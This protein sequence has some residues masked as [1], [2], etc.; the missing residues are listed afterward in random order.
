MGFRKLLWAPLFWPLAAL[1]ILLLFNIL[2][3]ANFAR[4][5]VRDG[6]LFGA[7]VDILKNGSMVMLL[8]T[9]MTLVIATG[10]IDL[11]V[12]SI[13]AVSG[14]AAA[15]LMTER[16]TPPLAASAAALALAAAIGAFNGAVITFAGLQP[17]VM[18]LSVL[19]AGRGVAQ[20]ITHDQKVRIEIPAFEH[21]GNGSFLGLPVPVFIAAA[22]AALALAA[23][24]K[25]SLGMYVEAI[26]GNPRASRLCGL[27]VHAVR[28]AVY[29]FCGLLAGAAGLVATA[30]IKEADVAN[31]GLYL[32]LDAI[33]AVVLGGTSLSG[34]RPRVG[35]A[36]V[37]ALFMQTL[38]TMLQ[39]LG[40]VTEHTLLIKAVVALAVCALQSPL[41]AK[42]ARRLAPKEAAG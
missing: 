21:F 42:W 36:L 10:G 22:M 1:G 13:M 3:T 18:T 11:S 41:L 38:T 33:L 24:R 26:G 20:A 34:G 30:V 2:F 6:R 7:M 37:G 32:E 15:L 29:A 12:G 16:G 23:C 31:C 8:A 4:L 40:V 14:A 5:E 9:G 25:T 39:M 19:V 17:I 27:P 35:G 28:I